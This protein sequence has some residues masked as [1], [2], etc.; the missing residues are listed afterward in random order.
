MLNKND[1]LSDIAFLIN[2]KLTLKPLLNYGLLGGDLGDI[3]F[4]YHYSRIDSSYESIA[5]GLLEKMLQS[6]SLQPRVATYCSG[7][8]GLGVGLLSLQRDG[9]IDGVETALDA[10]DPTI[11]KSLDL[12]ISNNN[13]DFLHGLIGIGFYLLERSNSSKEYSVSN[14]SKII[15]Y[16]DKSKIT[17]DAIVKWRYNANRLSKP[18]NISLSHGVS[19]IVVFL[20]RLLKS[21][22]LNE[23]YNAIIKQM[24]EGAVRYILSN[25]VDVDKLGCWFASSSIECDDRPHRSRLAWCYGDLGV[26]TALLEA[27]NT[28]HNSS[29][30]DIAIQVLLYSAKRRDINANYVNDFCVCHGSV[31]I[32]QIFRSHGIALKLDELLDAAD[33]WEKDTLS[34]VVMDGQG[35][36]TLLYYDPENGG[37]IERGGVLDGIAGAGLYFI[38]E[39]T[40]LNNLLLL[41]CQ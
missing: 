26:A 4:L 34:R 36:H 22:I 12:F 40:H 14:L 35:R 24:L 38:G 6:L 1:I 18:Y 16:L 28:L 8:A 27:G 29:V 3:I 39:Q 2:K 10:I 5:D 32:A 7:L 23:K 19:S 37:Y 21:G 20:C 11:A 41:P 13:I 33:Y 15:D 25:R 9:F 31:G 30:S 17:D